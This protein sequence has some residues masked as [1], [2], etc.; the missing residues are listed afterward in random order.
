[1]ERE[2]IGILFPGE[3][4]TAIGALLVA[5]GHEVVTTLEGRSRATIERCQGAE[6]TVLGSLSEVISE[7]TMVWSFIHPDGASDLAEQVL[8]AVAHVG[9]RPIYIDGNSIAPAVAVSIAERLAT[10]HVDFVDATIH[11]DSGR[12]RERSVLY[13]SG[14]QTERIASTLGGAMRLRLLGSEP[15]AASR[16]KMTIAGVS[17][18]ASALL[19]EVS[20]FA[21]RQGVLEAWIDD[22][23]HFYPALMQ[24]M[25]TMLPTYA[26]H[27]GRRAAE[28][29][30]IGR[31]ICELGLR[32]GLIAEAQRLV[33]RLAAHDSDEAMLDC[34]AEGTSL[35]DFLAALGTLS[36]LKPDPVSIPESADS[37]ISAHCSSTR[38]E[39]PHGPPNP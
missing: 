1:M 5:E 18:G 36:L 24:T 30:D 11:G 32:P 14:T 22:C 34:K 37:P 26:R 38:E 6:F 17:K 35:D 23:R 12:L 10:Q 8:A 13:L 39:R 19:M 28:L 9:S 15:G 20:S 27:S 21:A 2:R 3:M 7:S 29:N 16:F 31:T 25:E 33:A 4:G